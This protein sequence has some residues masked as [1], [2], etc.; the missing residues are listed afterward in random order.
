[1]DSGIVTNWSKSSPPLPW[2]VMIVSSACLLTGLVYAF[3]PPLAQQALI[4]VAGALPSDTA[5]MLS[6]PVSA[7]H[8]F[9]LVAVFSSLFVH[10]S[11]PHLVGNLAYLWVFGMPVERRTGVFFFALLFLLGG[12][13]AHIIVALR[14]PHLQTPVVGAS[15]AVSAVV[16]AYLGLFPS[17]R[18]GLYLPLGLYLQ[19]ARVPAL[20]VIGSWFT[21]QLVYTAFGP[22]TGAEAWWT[23]LAGFTLGLI[24][25]FLVRALD[26]VRS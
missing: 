25:A 17:R 18:I 2:V 7:W 26:L 1:M 3:L 9:G 16:G 12:A 6:Q 15:G 8:R 14:L 10:S 4:E 19:F 5:V 11:W 24:F 22:I 20:L 13:L 23:H 21:L